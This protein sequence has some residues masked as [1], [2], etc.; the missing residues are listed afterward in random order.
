[1][2]P[3]ILTLHEHAYRGEMMQHRLRIY[4]LSSF[5]RK[6]TSFR[7]QRHDV[8]RHHLEERWCSLDLQGTRR[9]PQE[10]SDAKHTSEMWE[11]IHRRWAMPWRLCFLQK[12]L[13]ISFYSTTMHQVMFIIISRKVKQCQLLTVFIFYYNDPWSSHWEVDCP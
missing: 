12:K 10:I 13:E 11:T 6:L 2:P 5:W 7:F 1:M 8:K 9:C 4:N 3:R